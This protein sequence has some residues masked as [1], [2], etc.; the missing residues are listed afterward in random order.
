MIKIACESQVV[1][2]TGMA[3]GTRDGE[4]EELFTMHPCTNSF[5]RMLPRSS[6]HAVAPVALAHHGL[7]QAKAE[8]FPQ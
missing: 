8:R 1:Q 4:Q 2:K 5:V 6:L 7:L 3:M